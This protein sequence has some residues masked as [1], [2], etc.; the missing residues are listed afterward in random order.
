MEQ[1]EAFVRMRVVRCCLKNLWYLI[2][3]P[4]QGHVGWAFG[5][6]D[7]LKNVPAYGKGVTLDGL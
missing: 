5:Q 4:I 7:L 1:E 6:T 2:P 3:E